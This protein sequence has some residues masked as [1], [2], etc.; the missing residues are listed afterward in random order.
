MMSVVVMGSAMFAGRARAQADT[1][2]RPPVF[3]S[4]VSAGSLRFSSGRTQQGVSVIFQLQPKPW[5]TFSITPGYASTTFNDTT[6]TGLTDIPLSAGASHTWDDAPWSPSI[7]GSLTASIA[8]GG[9]TASTLGLGHGSLSTYW[10]LGASPTDAFNFD[11]ATWRPLSGV[12][13]NGSVDIEGSFDAGKTSFSGGYS[14]E[15]GTPDSGAVLARSVAGGVS[16]PLAG[17]VRLNLDAS[18]GITSSAPTW[19]FAIGIGTAFGGHSPLNPTTA[20]RR[21]GKAFG[22]KSASG[23][24]YNNGKGSCKKAGTC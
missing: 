13:G 12:S 11:V 5:L 23:S 17:K 24:G 9:A 19:T 6:H 4:G 2:D 8:P 10:A 1:T 15:V 21:I 14:L 22:S 20:L 18:H 16:F 3:A 7:A